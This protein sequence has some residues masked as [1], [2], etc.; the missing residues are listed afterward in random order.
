MLNN[1]FICFFLFSTALWI[2]ADQKEERSWDFIDKQLKL[3]YG[4]ML[5]MS[6]LSSED[7]FLKH[8]VCNPLTKRC[9]CDHQS[10][11]HDDRCQVRLCSMSEECSL[12]YENSICLFGRCQCIYGLRADGMCATVP[13]NR[14]LLN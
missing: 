6:C 5:N 10:M 13:G 4:S 14:L 11:V 3:A 9:E 12:Q 1:K 7:C 2:E 8:S